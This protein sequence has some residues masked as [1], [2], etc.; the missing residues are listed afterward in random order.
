MNILFIHQNFPGQFKH[1]AVALVKRGDRV[2]A[3]G[4]EDRPAPAGVHVIRYPLVR[5]NSRDGHPWLLD[6]ESKVIRAESAWQAMTRLHADGFC[7]DLV[8]AHPGWG[9]ALFVRDVWPDIAV[10]SHFEFYYH[11]S[12]ADVGFDPEFPANTRD[13]PRLR[14]K[15][16]VNLMNLEQCTAGIAPTQWQKS[17]HPATYHD[18]LTVIHDGIDTDAVAPSV[19]ARLELASRGLRFK[20]GNEVITFVSRNLEPYRG[21][22]VFMRALPQ[23]LAQR[24]NAHVMVIGGDDVS[25]G[26]RPNEGTWRQRFLT[27]VADK[28]DLSRVHFLGKVPYPTYLR[29]LQVSAVH[30]YLTY[31]FVL[32]WSLLEA[33]SAG[34]LVVASDTPPVREVIRHGDNGLLVDFFAPDRLAN[35]VVDVLSRPTEFAELRGRARQTIVEGYD[36]HRVCL[37]G[38]LALIDSIL[39]SRRL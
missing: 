4:I 39:H 23:I 11:A 6:T 16:F 22:H 20:S 9:E 2:T 35:Q 17:L 10:L 34:C 37:P 28:L 36:L 12:G 25:Y 5:G 26:A 13:A 18:K 24:P 30:V 8:I 33:M 15:N 27:E 21:Y 31:P 3:L 38:Q 29:A 19:D 14:S 32:S 7:P 1:Q